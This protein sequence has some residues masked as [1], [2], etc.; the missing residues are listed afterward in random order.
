MTLRS[1]FSEQLFELYLRTLLDALAWM[2][3]LLKDSASK[4]STQHWKVWCFILLSLQVY[5]EPQALTLWPFCKQLKHNCFD[6]ANFVL[7]EADMFWNCRH[8]KGLWDSEQKSLQTLTV[9]YNWVLQC[10]FDLFLLLDWA[11]NFT[12]YYETWKFYFLSPKN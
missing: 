10:Y 6:L 9:E 2:A 12:W 11:V 5:L 7:S 3:F 4:F 8:A 1:D